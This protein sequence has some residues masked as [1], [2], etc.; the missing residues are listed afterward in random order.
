MSA[1]DKLV[2]ATSVIA[3]AVIEI[4]NEHLGKLKVKPAI[5][6]AKAGEIREASRDKGLVHSMCL[7]LSFRC[8]DLDD[9][10]LFNKADI[11]KML[12]EVDS[13]LM[14]DLYNEVMGAVYSGKSTATTPDSTTG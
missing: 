5:S 3:G 9:N 10:P 8:T 2:S 11:T 13:N 4:E 1:I 12:L 14:T 7:E 6:C